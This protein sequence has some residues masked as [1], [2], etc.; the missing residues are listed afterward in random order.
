M[1]GEQH[2]AAS[3]LWEV[4]NPSDAVS[5]RTDD[6]RIAIGVTVVVGEGHYGLQD[7]KGVEYPSLLFLSSKEQIEKML[8]PHFPSLEAL[9]AYLKANPEKTIA[10]LDSFAVVG[11][12]QRVDFEK[13]VEAITDE[14]RRRNYV[15]E[16][17][18]R[19]RT[20]INDICTYARALVKFYR[21]RPAAGGNAPP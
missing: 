4:I 3:R 10:A 12:P 15:A 20:S 6:T 19:H 9:F 7:E 5:F 11:I 14:E 17:N 18:D 2:G 16:F 13:A 1:A 8:Q 21:K